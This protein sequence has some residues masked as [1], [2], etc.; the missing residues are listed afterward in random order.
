M[1]KQICSLAKNKAIEAIKGRDTVMYKHGVWN[2]YGETPVAEVIRR[3]NGSGYG[4]DVDYDADTDTMYVC[5][6]ANAD[7][8]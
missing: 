5:T 2:R 8:W 7:M 4:A 1:R 3:I 6:P